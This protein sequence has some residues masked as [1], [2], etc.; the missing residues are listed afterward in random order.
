M[1][2]CSE[3]NPERPDTG[4]ASVPIDQ[5]RLRAASWLCR[6]LAAGQNQ[7]RGHVSVASWTGPRTPQVRASPQ[8]AAFYT[9]L[10]NIGTS[11][12]KNTAA[13]RCFWAA[14]HGPGFFPQLP[15]LSGKEPPG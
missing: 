5:E 8:E 7:D 9:Q 11:V 3:K 10:P 15:L 12:L 14:P 13:L 1:R 6:G 2:I 4:L